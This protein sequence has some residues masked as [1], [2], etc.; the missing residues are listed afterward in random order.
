MCTC[1]HAHVN[2]CVCVC[3]C[4]TDACELTL[5]PNTAHQ[6]LQL[7]DDLRQATH[8]PEEQPHPS[9]PER[10]Q[11]RPQVLCSQSVSSDHR[12]CYW[13]TAWSQD[14][15]ISIGVA[16]GSIDRKG[17]SPD[18]LLGYNDRSWCLFYSHG[19][20]SAWHNQKQTLVP[21]NRIRV[22]PDPKPTQNQDQSESRSASPLTP[23]LDLNRVGAYLDWAT[24]TLAF[25]SISSDAVTRLHAFC[26]VF[27]EPLYPAFRLREINTSLILC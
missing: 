11:F 16:Y 6:R 19:R 23:V 5:D 18:R 22:L 27:T 4:V 10:F 13:E 2:E 9:H 17:W 1:V 8:S 3:V 24:G 21:E 15:G 12:R 7:S 25:Y 20:Y 14:G 26:A